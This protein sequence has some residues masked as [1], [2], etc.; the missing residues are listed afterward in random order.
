MEELVELIEPIDNREVLVV[1]IAEHGGGILR[2]VVTV[3]DD[4]LPC[5]R[6][7]LS[8]HHFRKHIR[9]HIELRVRLFDRC[10]ELRDLCY[11]QLFE[12]ELCANYVLEVVCELPF[13]RFDV[14]AS[15]VG[16]FEVVVRA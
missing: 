8:A 7:E 14:C 1:E 12:V 2:V 15:P 9:H 10:K 16:G 13:P 5:Q 4:V 11:S 6:V 3:R